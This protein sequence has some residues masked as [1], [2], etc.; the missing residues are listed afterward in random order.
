MVFAVCVPTG[1]VHHGSGRAAV[2]EPS[3]TAQVTDDS[4]SSSAVPGVGT[5]SGCA[6]GMISLEYS[7]VDCRGTP[8]G[9]RLAS[10]EGNG[11]KGSGRGELHR[12]G[13]FFFGG[14]VSSVVLVDVGSWV[15]VVRAFQVCVLRRKASGIF[16]TGR[17]TEMN[18]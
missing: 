9:E 16:V 2:D 6:E 13:V 3:V 17:G 12:D 1:D 7:L 14:G 10:K 15:A 11:G 5:G 8:V 18:V 4:A